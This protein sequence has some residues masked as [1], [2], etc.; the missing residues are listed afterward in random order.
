MALN[1][2][3][4]RLGFIL[5]KKTYSYA[6]AQSGIPKSTLW[7][8]QQGIRKLPAKYT[9]PLRNLYQRESYH[10]LHDAGF[11]AINAKQLS[12]YS[13]ESARL[14]ESEMNLLVQKYTLGGLWQMKLKAQREGRSFDEDAEY[15]KV[16]AAV[17]KG[18]QKSKVDWQL[19][20]EYDD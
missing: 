14:K 5:Q 1:I 13:P 8:V 20:G 10:R 9:N 16:R 4:R 17:I 11:S 15:E 12:W 18:L 3:Q 2:A 19:M 6:S 7:Y